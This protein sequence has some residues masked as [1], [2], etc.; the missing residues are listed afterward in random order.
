M[1][2]RLT[3]VSWFSE[4]YSSS[5]AHFLDLIIVSGRP[6]DVSAVKTLY[7]TLGYKQKAGDKNQ[8]GF[9]NLCVSTPNL[10]ISH[11]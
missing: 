4:I 2:R 10:R 6:T 1:G 3:A 5:V 11:Y 8:I 7:G 9:N